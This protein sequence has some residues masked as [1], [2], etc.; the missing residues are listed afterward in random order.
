[1]LPHEQL[2]LGIAVGL[3]LYTLLHWSPSRRDVLA[4]VVAA[5]MADLVSVDHLRRDIDAR[6]AIVTQPGNL[7]VSP[8]FRTGIALA[9]ATASAALQVLRQ[10]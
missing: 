8:Y 10:H 2:T 4:A 9:L 1:M 6:S 3:F 7:V 5:G